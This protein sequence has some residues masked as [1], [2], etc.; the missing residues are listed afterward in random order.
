[1]VQ[2]VNENWEEIPREQVSEPTIGFATVAPVDGYA[3]TPDATSPEL[4]YQRPDTATIPTTPRREA[5]K[6][7]SDGVRLDGVWQPG[8]SAR[9]Q[10]PQVRVPRPN[11]LKA[12]LSGLI[13]LALLG[14][15]IYLV[16]RLYGL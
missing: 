7:I 1:M 2:P 8:G 10:T 16:M 15:G 9:Q 11:L 4:R 3:F 14:G 5:P 6:R 12:L 13:P